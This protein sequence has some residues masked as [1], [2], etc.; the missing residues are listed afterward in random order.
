MIDPPRL[1]GRGVRHVFLRDMVLPASIGVYPHEQAAPQR[2][3]INVDLGVTEDG[4]ARAPA[5]RAPAVGRDDL[6][7]WWITKRSPVRCA[8]WS[9]PGT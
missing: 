5:C 4:T 1:A 2:I 8:P 7:G 6:A 9:P 3:R